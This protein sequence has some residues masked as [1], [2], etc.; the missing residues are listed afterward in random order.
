MQQVKL[1]NL[2][3]DDPNVNGFVEHMIEVMAQ[4]DA[5]T[6]RLYTIIHEFP[7]KLENA[8]KGIDTTTKP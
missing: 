7:A 1:H 2:N 4:N 6:S 5:N 3:L 8:K